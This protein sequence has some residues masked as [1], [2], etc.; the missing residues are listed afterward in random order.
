M[1]VQHEALTASTP[2]PLSNT[3]AGDIGDNYEIPLPEPSSSFAGLKDRIKHHYEI[4]SDYYFSLWYV[5][6]KSPVG[7]VPCLGEFAK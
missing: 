2:N 5:Y 6:F 3:E 4:C 7:L 1:K